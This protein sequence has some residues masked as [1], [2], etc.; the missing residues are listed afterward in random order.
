MRFALK[1]LHKTQSRL[2]PIISTY[3]LVVHFIIYIYVYDLLTLF[4]PVL[5][6]YKRNV[7]EYETHKC[8]YTP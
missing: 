8:M 6:F 5:L 1:V 7:Y 2:N 4:N 3:P